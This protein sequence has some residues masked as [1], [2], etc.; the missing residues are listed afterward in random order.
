MFSDGSRVLCT[1]LACAVASLVAILFK[2][3]SM[4]RN[5]DHMHGYTQITDVGIEFPVDRKSAIQ[6]I[7]PRRS[8]LLPR[9]EAHSMFV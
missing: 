9:R 3:E 2:R 8:Q 5:G 7:S 4:R 6:R 1:V